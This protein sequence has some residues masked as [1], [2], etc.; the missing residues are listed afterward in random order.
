LTSGSNQNWSLGPSAK[1]WTVGDSVDASGRILNAIPF[2]SAGDPRVPVTGTTLGTSANGRGFDG[3]TNLVNTTLWGRTDPAIILSGIDA[4]LIEA[5]ARLQASDIPG[6][7][8]ILN[9]LRATSQNIGSNNGTAIN[10]G[11]MA[12]L[13]VPATTAAAQDLLFRERAF[14]TFGRGQRLGSLRRLVRQYGRTQATA[15]PTGT[16]FKGGVY[17]SDVN[18]PISPD[19]LNND[20]FKGCQ[21]RNA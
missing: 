14:W 3:S 13:A 11:V 10:S 20:K 15:F 16:F 2:A 19:E 9:A 17:G 6:M 7:I 4:R 1:R 8:V 5:E 12:P 18:F 21:D